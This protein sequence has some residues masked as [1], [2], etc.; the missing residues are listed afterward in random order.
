MGGAKT[1]SRDKQAEDWTLVHSLEHSKRFGWAGRGD[2]HPLSDT[3][4]H[5]HMQGKKKKKRLPHGN[6]SYSRVR[7]FILKT[8]RFDFLL[9]D[10][11]REAL[12]SK[13]RA[14]LIKSVA[15]TAAHLLCQRNSRT[16]PVKSLDTL[17]CVQTFHWYC[18]SAQYF[19]EGRNKLSIVNNLWVSYFFLMLKNT[20][21]NRW[22]DWYHPH[23]CTISMKLQPVA[24]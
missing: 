13:H 9:L 24:G 23:V 3:R 2:W 8:W 7:S 17:K 18:T 4:M 12:W 5:S 6:M 19:T 11:K 20:L 10:T 15:P 21:K 14:V 22:E 1:P 16:V